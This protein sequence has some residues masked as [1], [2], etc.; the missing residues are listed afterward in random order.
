M[1]QQRETTAIERSPMETQTP[2][3]EEFG[4]ARREAETPSASRDSKF[5]VDAVGFRIGA[6][7]SQR[8]ISAPPP[9]RRN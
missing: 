2:E 6:T 4:S 3:K 7:S 9:M 1:R 8:R 5:L